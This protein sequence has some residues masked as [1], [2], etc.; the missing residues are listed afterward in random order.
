MILTLNEIKRDEKNIGFIAN[1][2]IEVHVQGNRILG[3]TRKMGGVLYFCDTD[4][5]VRYY[6]VLKGKYIYPFNH[7]LRIINSILDLEEAIMDL[8][9]IEEV[10]ALVNL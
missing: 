9:S 7:Q 1:E 4:Q 3:S 5:T 2:Y 6:L 10:M 8:D